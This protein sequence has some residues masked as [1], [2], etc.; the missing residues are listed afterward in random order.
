MTF[1]STIG[2]LG[3]NK[4]LSNLVTFDQ[5]EYG[6]SSPSPTCYYDMGSPQM[7]DT[8]TVTTGVE[9]KIFGDLKNLDSGDCNGSS[10][11]LF[12]S[13]VG[14]LK[15]GNIV[16]GRV[17]MG[18]DAVPDLE[19]PEISID[20]QRLI[21]ESQFSVDNLSI[22]S[23][24][25]PGKLASTTYTRHP[26]SFTL[27]SSSNTTSNANWNSNVNLRSSA[28]THMQASAHPY[29][30]SAIGSN[31][32]STKVAEL[33]P[34]YVKREP[35]EDPC[36]F[37]SSCHQQQNQSP[38]HSLSGL[39]R[40]HNIVQTNRSSYSNAYGIGPTVSNNGLSSSKNING[41]SHQQKMVSGGN[42]KR[43]KNHVNKGSDEYRKRRERNNVAVRK[44]REKAKVRSSE[45]EH[46][47]KELQLEN[48]MLVR[49]VES[50]TKE[51]GVLKALF[52]NGGM[53]P[54]SI[55]DHQ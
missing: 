31:G 35:Q 49:R 33:L 8:Q 42:S 39:N 20:I 9:D 3:N 40:P 6:I 32:Q 19:N 14:R 54:E 26:Q 24:I 12:G 34:S 22:F 5:Q 29:T 52:G 37:V 15:G 27:L 55:L 51:V 36:P 43:G 17:G 18:D 47:M 46:K 28:A 10:G 30:S 11:Y 53:P 23:E 16:I 1:S 4:H 13:G 21:E 7:Y 25:T 50:L 44:S 41:N 2:G 45:T 48:D 38:H